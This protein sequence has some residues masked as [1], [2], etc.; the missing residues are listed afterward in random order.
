MAKQQVASITA[1]TERFDLET[2]LHGKSG[3]SL[4]G[5]PTGIGLVAV[6]KGIPAKHR[7]AVFEAA[8]QEIDEAEQRAS[9]EQ[10][11]RDKVSAMSSDEF[12]RFIDGVA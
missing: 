9:I 12:E 10:V 7:Q 11:L 8:I 6:L 4:P 5:D 3:R 1:P 2:A